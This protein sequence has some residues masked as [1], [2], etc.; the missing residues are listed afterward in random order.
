MGRSE[1]NMPK[2]Y[3]LLEG[4]AWVIIII[5]SAVL[6][7]EYYER[8]KEKTEVIAKERAEVQERELETKTM[9]M[10][11]PITYSDSD[12]ENDLRLFQT[13]KPF[14]VNDWKQQLTFDNIDIKS[15]QTAIANKQE[16]QKNARESNFVTVPPIFQIPS[17]NLLAPS[18]ID[19]LKL[20]VDQIKFS[21]DFPLFTGNTRSIG[22]EGILFY[23]PPGTGK[24]ERAI[25]TIQT[26]I[27]AAERE[28]PIAV[29]QLSGSEFESKFQGG[30]SNR[31][32][33]YLEYFEF[34]GNQIWK[35]GENSKKGRNV[36]VFFDELDSVFSAGSGSSRTAL[37]A[38]INNS[39]RFLIIGATNYPEK[40]EKALLGRFPVRYFVDMPSKQEIRNLY[41]WMIGSHM[42]K[43]FTSD[44]SDDDK[45]KVHCLFEIINYL[46]LKSSMNKKI[47][48][49]LRNLDAELIAKYVTPK[50]SD[51]GV[52]TVGYTLRDVRL[53]SKS[54]IYTIGKLRGV[55]GDTDR[56][57][58]L[59]DVVSLCDGKQYENVIK[60]LLTEKRPEATIKDYSQNL[61]YVM[62]S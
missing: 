57:M 52:Y 4:L 7:A 44:L 56:E 35:R 6:L 53:V 16:V 34:V 54:L 8:K 49:S 13:V 41:Y 47:K 43:K 33:V 58:T 3:D 55:G 26:F 28:Y 42:M 27:A 61:K 15:F 19:R 45:T 30:P 59:D 10:D 46:S 21:Q 24:T 12:F 1:K 17:V 29:F 36:I 5:V 62:E 20:A 22:G 37:L 14:G 40:I 32:S 48:E 25:I 38:K 50:I 11:T 9:N 18:D 51:Y 31:I 60:I 2:G 23:G 39:Q